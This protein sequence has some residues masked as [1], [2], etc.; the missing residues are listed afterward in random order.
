MSK[1]EK[2][3]N[4]RTADGLRREKEA[5]KKKKLKERKEGR[6]ERRKK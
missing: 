5:R 4:E 1:Q 6:K 2:S 3:D